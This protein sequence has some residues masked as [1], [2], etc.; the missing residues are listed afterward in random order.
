MIKGKDPYV[1]EKDLSIPMHAS[2]VWW[3]IKYKAWWIVL[4]YLA[5]NWWFFEFKVPYAIFI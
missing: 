4:R 3:S 1:F 2:E 5:K